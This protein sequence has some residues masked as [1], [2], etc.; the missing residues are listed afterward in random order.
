MT[1]LRNNES[2]KRRLKLSS[3]AP[4]EELRLIAKLA[5]S[6]VPWPQVS[7]NVRALRLSVFTR[8]ERVAYIGA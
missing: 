8:R 4:K 5:A 3:D 1:T 2:G 7:I 6:L